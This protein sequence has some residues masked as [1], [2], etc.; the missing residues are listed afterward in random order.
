MRYLYVIIICF[1]ISSCNANQK[2]LTVKE[3]DTTT[4]FCPEDG[5]CTFEVLQEKSLKILQDY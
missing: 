2:V 3:V 1:L 5:V 4:S